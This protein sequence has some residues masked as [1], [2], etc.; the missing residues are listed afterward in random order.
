MLH[1][2]LASLPL[3]S[4]S[5][6]TTD[7]V[8]GV[9]WT[10]D[11]TA[12]HGVHIVEV[13]LT[14]PE[15]YLRVTREE[16]APTT[17]TAFA[18]LTGSVATINGDWID[19]D[20]DRP[21]GLAVG[22]GWHWTDTHDWDGSIN[23]PGDWSFLACRAS[24]DCFFDPVGSLQTWDTVW[25]NVLGGN[26]DRLVVDGVLKTPVW[27]SA[28]R[29]RS[30]ICLDS[31]GTKLILAVAE[32]DGAGANGLG[33]WLE[34]TSHTFDGFT[35]S[36]FAA[37]MFDLGCWNA[38][39][40]DGGGSSD[41][42]ID[43]SRVNDRSPS[44]PSERM[45]VS[46]LS[47]IQ[48]AATDPACASTMNG[49]ACDGDE[50][51]ICQG[52][53]LETL[54]CGF[55]G[56][57]CEAADDTAFCVDPVCTHG[58]MEDQCIDEDLMTRCHHG[59][60]DEFDCS[61]YGYSCEDTAG[62]ARCTDAACPHGGDAAWCEGDTL[63]TCAPEDWGGL[64]VGIPQADVDCAA[65]GQACQ[66]GACVDADTGTSG[67][68]GDDGGSGGDGG[69]GSSGDG[70]SGSGASG[71]SG[72]SGGADDSSLGDS[73]GQSPGGCGCGTTRAM[74]LGSWLLP[75]ALLLVGRRR[76]A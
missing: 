15:L 7:V 64:E 6:Y 2:L 56:W 37:Y 8:D 33:A 16:E 48:A 26:G 1:L 22:N 52:G 28:E 10:L 4:A 49:R 36:A 19:T 46:H 44:E 60:A 24:K 41:M 50:L 34:G 30:G 53:T 5:T 29:P 42:I 70:G 43:G 69:N 61:A 20:H 18:T 72:S 73:L 59:M 65:S 51:Q 67:D 38:M 76:R 66:D 47:I 74:P 25:Q 45:L 63:K 71:G 31:T 55:Y 75:W 57:A 35:P 3:A 12:D 58:G 17:T 27:D 11:H 62:S 40:L 54:D 13:D 68:S 9:V 21:L 14:V 32:G 39:G 23:P